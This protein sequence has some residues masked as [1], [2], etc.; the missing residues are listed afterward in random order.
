VLGEASYLAWKPSLS[1]DHWLAKRWGLYGIVEGQWT[2]DALIPNEQ[3][4][5]AGADSVRGYKE[6]EVSGDR[7]V[8]A[9]FEVRFYPLGRPDADGK[10]LLYTEVF[11][12]AAQVRLVNP[13]GPQISLLSIAS[14]GL[15]LRAQGWHGLHC[16]FDLAQALRD[17]GRGVNGPITHNGTRRL[18]ASVGYS[19]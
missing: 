16:A 6:S 8:R 18:E 17:G 9:T 7:G 11:V 19:F 3:Y 5:T 10:R 1:A 15:G 14:T 4:V 13:S 2:S 12:D